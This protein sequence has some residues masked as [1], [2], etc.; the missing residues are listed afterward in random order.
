MQATRNTDGYAMRGM[1][2]DWRLADRPGWCVADM[3]MR[4][5]E[6]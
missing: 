3:R 6:R 4:R 5:T 2:D 1:A